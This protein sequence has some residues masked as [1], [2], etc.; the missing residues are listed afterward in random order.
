L[1]T[2]CEID[3]SLSSFWD[4]LVVRSIERKPN[5]VINSD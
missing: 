5:S 3:Q 4:H 2:I 1:E